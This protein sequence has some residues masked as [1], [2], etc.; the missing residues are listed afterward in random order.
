MI[1]PRLLFSKMTISQ[2]E[3]G[4]PVVTDKSIQPQAAECTATFVLGFELIFPYLLD[5]TQIVNYKRFRCGVY[6]VTEVFVKPF[7]GLP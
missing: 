3:L 5:E 1:S 4:P 2:L 7:P 6:Y